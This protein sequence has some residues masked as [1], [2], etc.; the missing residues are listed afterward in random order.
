M[1]EYQAETPQCTL[2]IYAQQI[3]Q[4]RSVVVHLLATSFFISCAKCLWDAVGNFLG[5]RAGA[6]DAHSTGRCG[7]L[8]L[9]GVPATFN[10]FK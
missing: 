5:N 6:Q 10:H 2:A 3:M 4:R 9:L 1:A 8:D 7:G